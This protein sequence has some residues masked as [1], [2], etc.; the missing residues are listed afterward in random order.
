MWILLY[1]SDC[2][3]VTNHILNYLAPSCHFK[4][5]CSLPSVFCHLGLCVIWAQQL[6]T[7]FGVTGSNPFF[8]MTGAVTCCLFMHFHA[9]V[10][11][12]LVS[13]HCC[14]HSQKLQNLTFSDDAVFILYRVM[15]LQWNLVILYPQLSSFSSCMWNVFTTL[16][17]SL[18]TKGNTMILWMISN[19]ITPVL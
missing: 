2:S 17:I 15:G 1:A 6:M 12:I 4:I 3:V 11:L 8:S 9:C 16:L 19:R 10:L 7:C 18:V 14:G 5:L 13:R